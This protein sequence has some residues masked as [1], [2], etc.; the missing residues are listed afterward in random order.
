MSALNALSSTLSTGVNN[1][2]AQIK[3]VQTQLATGK[4]NLDPGQLGTVTRLSSQ[5]TGYNSAADNIAQAQSA[6]SVAQTGLSSIND[7]MTQMIDLANKA[8]NASLSDADRSKL[9]TT[10]QSLATQITS[11]TDNTEMNGVN[12]IK[13]GATN[14]T[15]QSG[16]TATDTMTITAVA[17]D[18][19]TLGINAEDISTAAGAATAITD[20][21]G[22]L[23]TL[24]T[25]QSSLAA[26]NAGLAAK[27]KTDA[28]IATNLQSSIDV[29]VKPDQAKL[30]MDLSSLNNQQSI[31]YYLIS[32][33]NT[34]ASAAMTIF[35]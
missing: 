9:N 6:I 17:S 22:A 33:L 18:A 34:A 3:D 35:R 7:L 27:G 26:D 31:D 2:Q 5:V 12:L 10:F 1:V 11:I 16:I 14:A 19:T 13:S 29:I 20:L 15:V 28:A 4:K 25:N 24:S 30:Q 23:D 21:K 32:Q 8:S